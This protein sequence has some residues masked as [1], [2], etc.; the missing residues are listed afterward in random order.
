[1][2]Q[3]LDLPK[4]FSIS[5]EEPKFGKYI[6]FSLYREPDLLSWNGYYQG[7]R[8]RLWNTGDHWVVAGYISGSQACYFRTTGERP[9]LTVINKLVQC[10]CY[11]IDLM[12]IK[13]E[14]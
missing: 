10:T 3:G 6:K 14:E 12:T 8:I 11:Y 1:M 7:E 2:D 13:T 9:D 5:Y 4:Q